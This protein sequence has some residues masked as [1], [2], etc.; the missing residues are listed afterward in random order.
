MQ[1]FELFA[2]LRTQWRVS[3]GGVTGLDYG[4]VYHKLDRLGLSAER[5]DE[6]E[7]QIQVLESA[8]LEEINRK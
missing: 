4:V 1:A 5:Y 6:I 7:A 3:L 2:S 8:A